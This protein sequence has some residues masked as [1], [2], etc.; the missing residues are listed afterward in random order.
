[1]TTTTALHIWVADLTFPGYMDWWHRQAAEFEAAHPEY[2]VELRALGFFT[3]PQEISAAVAEGKG[4]AV[5]EYYFYMSQIARDTTDPDG[6]PRYTSVRRAIGDRTEILGEPVVIDDIIPAM[7]DYY[8]V[9]G[10]LMSMPSVGTT[11]VLYANTEQMAAAGLNGLPATW[12]EVDRACAALADTRPGP[13]IGWANHGMFFQQALASQGG[14]LADNGNGRA[15]RA[16]KVD[17]ASPQMLA[18]VRWWRDLHTAGHYEYTGTIPDWQGTFQSF[19]EQRVGLRISSSNDVNYMVQAAAGAG[20]G[21]EVGAWPYNSAVPYAGN[22]IAGSS[23]WLAD[24]LDEATRDG[25]L[26]FLQFTHSPRK[27]ADRHKDNSFLPLTHAAYDLL[28]EEGWFAAHPYHR[29]PSDQLATYPDRAGSKGVWPP[30]EGALFGEF[31][32]A[33][34]IMTHAMGDVLA[35]GADPVERFAQASADAQALLD[36]YN[37]TCRSPVPG[38]APETLRVEYFTDA[39]TYS[40]ADLDEVVRTQR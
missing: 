26:A 24:G 28:D 25:A 6:R 8:T 4:P 40:G 15:G 16:T 9:G 23:L 7:R 17:L 20:F 32:R 35:H 13:T 36:A 34:D 39:R 11:S 1:M 22:A 18:W 10:D 27:A 31:A 19:A 14:L 37:A 30:S 33:Q 29:V 38:S 3:A 12:A 5:A 2:R 21:L